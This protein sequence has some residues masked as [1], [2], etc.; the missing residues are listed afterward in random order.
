MDVQERRKFCGAVTV[1]ERGQIVVPDHAR[2]D[3]G[4]Q[5]GERFLVFGD[6]EQGLALAIEGFLRETMKNI[7]SFLDVRPVMD[8]KDET[9]EPTQ[10]GKK[11]QDSKRLLLRGKAARAIPGHP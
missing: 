5:A 6:L 2:R 1:G 9:S 4:I 3:F 8:E 11:G 7:T 10:R